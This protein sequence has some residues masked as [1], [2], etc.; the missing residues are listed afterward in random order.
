MDREPAR[1]LNRS[2][3]ARIL[4]HPPEVVVLTS[5]RTLTLL[6]ALVLMVALG[7]ACNEKAPSEPNYCEENPENC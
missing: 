6:A 4:T 1:Q 3:C 7:S 2:R 5:R